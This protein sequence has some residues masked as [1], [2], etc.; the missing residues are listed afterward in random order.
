[1]V[2]MTEAQSWRL[3]LRRGVKWKGSGIHHAL[4]TTGQTKDW[5]YGT[6]LPS[7]KGKSRKEASFSIL[8]PSFSIHVNTLLRVV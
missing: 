8:Q 6:K 5:E 1:M 3:V 7:S 2:D 4:V